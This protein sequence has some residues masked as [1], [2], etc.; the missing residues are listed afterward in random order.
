MPFL[1]MWVHCTQYL[2]YTMLTLSVSWLVGCF[3]GRSV[4]LFQYSNE[5]R[6][7]PDGCNKIKD[8]IFPNVDEN[9]AA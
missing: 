1:I 8:K 2:T 7:S 4:F 3:G 9:E 5:G 6:C